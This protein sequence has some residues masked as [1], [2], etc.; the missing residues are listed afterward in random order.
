[1][2][3]L[4]PSPLLTPP[5]C[6]KRN[7]NFYD[8]KPFPSNYPVGIELVSKNMISS[9]F[10]L[11]S[12]GF[13]WFFRGFFVTLFSAHFCQAGV[14]WDGVR[15]EILKCPSRV[16]G[17]GAVNMSIQNLNFVHKRLT[18]CKKYVLCKSRRINKRNNSLQETELTVSTQVSN[19]H[20]Y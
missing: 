17:G 12:P 8:F 13:S 15:E 6:P 11:F 20:L 9:C 10:K 16:G 14:G 7:R 4:P 5:T 2:E 18:C 3:T 19:G 1:M